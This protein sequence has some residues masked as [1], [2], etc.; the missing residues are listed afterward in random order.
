[1]ADEVGLPLRPDLE[2]LRE[3]LGEDGIRS[4]RE[5]VSRYGYEGLPSWLLPILGVGSL[6][7]DPLRDPERKD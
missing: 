2:K 7:V 6:L 4:V 5:H 1:M 3:L